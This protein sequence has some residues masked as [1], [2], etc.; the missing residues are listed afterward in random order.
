M[1]GC[2]LHGQHCRVPWG[3]DPAHTDRRRPYTLDELADRNEPP[4]RYA[5]PDTAAYLDAW[6]L[7]RAL[8]RD[9]RLNPQEAAA[10]L[11]GIALR[12]TGRTYDDFMRDEPAAARARWDAFPGLQREHAP[13]DGPPDRT[14]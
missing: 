1:T 2:R 6:H 11:D 4:H 3:Y 12:L 8:R 14:G 5:Y 10:R 13:S 7:W 9:G